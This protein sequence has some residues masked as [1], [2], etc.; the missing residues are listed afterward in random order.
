MVA[1]TLNDR[2]REGQ[3]DALTA[4]PAAP[5]AARREPALRVLPDRRG[6]ERLQATSRI[7]Q[8]MASVQL[9]VQRCLLNLEPAVAP[10]TIDP[11]RWQWMKQYRTWEANRKVFLYPENWLEPNCVTIRARSSKNSARNSYSRT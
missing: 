3:R 2:L 7:K 9:F 11:H 1:G 6:H 4:P 10:T 8:A 5:G